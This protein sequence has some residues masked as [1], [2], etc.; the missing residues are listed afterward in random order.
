ML[1]QVVDTTTENK[2]EA[3]K[4]IIKMLEDSDARNDELQNITTDS[5]IAN[6]N[7]RL[8]YNHALLALAELQGINFK[9]QID[10]HGKWGESLAVHRKGLSGTYIDNPGNLSSETLNLLT[11]KVTEAYQNVRQDLQKPVADV[12]ELVIELQKEKNFGFVK[13]TTFGNQADLYK[14]MYVFENGDMK[15]K[16]PW[17]DNTL[18][19]VETKFLKYAITR[20]N[21]NRHPDLTESEIQEMINNDDASYFRIPLAKGDV[22]SMTS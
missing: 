19:A 13:K 11:K 18:S 17:K 21:Q 3:L 2:I 14:N 9:Q 6:S 4:K 1:D 10:K 20:I 16:N 8:V 12:R 7:L 22:S 15:F 5:T